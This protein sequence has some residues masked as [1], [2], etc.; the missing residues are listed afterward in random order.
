MDDEARRDLR[1]RAE[2]A[3]LN[4]EDFVW[5]DGW[6]FAVCPRL[7]RTS[8]RLLRGPDMAAILNRASAELTSAG[9]VCRVDAMCVHCVH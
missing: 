1:A 7:L 8:A 3:G 5:M 2:A 6:T 4:L 9:H